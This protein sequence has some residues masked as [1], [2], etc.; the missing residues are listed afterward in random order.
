VD[1]QNGVFQK[2]KRA[3]LDAKLQE[4]D[5][6]ESSPSSNS[7]PHG[8]MLPV[9]PSNFDL[10]T[11]TSP[12]RLYDRSRPTIAATHGPLSGDSGEPTLTA[13][14]VMAEDIR[15]TRIRIATDGNICSQLDFQTPP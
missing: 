13:R 14:R 8:Q 6:E 1:F 11:Q 9:R 15:V 4:S 10:N 2:A 7:R 3:W 12:V 5:A